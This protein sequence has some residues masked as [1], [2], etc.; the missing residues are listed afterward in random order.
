MPDG[1]DLEHHHADGVGDDVVQLARDPRALLCHRDARG[2]L[3]LPFGPHGARLRR[4]GLLRSLAQS[5]ACGPGDPELDGDEDELCGRVTGDVVDNRRNACEDDRQAGPRLP[6]VA[7]VP[8]Q[9]GGRQ[10]DEEQAV[11]ERDQDAVDKGERRRE[12]PVGSRSGEGKAPAGE[13]R[14][15]RT[16]TAGTANHMLVLG[17]PGESVE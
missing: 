16:A 12:D 3:T 14:Q 5:E 4:L 15:H 17:A 2:R 7:Q 6:G 1:A 11:D 8:E 13:E 10:P 9:G